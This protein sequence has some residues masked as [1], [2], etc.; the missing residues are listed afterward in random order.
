[1]RRHEYTYLDYLSILVEQLG[2]R[3]NMAA[4]SRDYHHPYKPYDIQLELMNAV[5]DCIADG[6]IGIFESPTGTG[7]SLSLICSSL[8]WLRQT[9]EEML[10]TQMSIEED[11]E[12]PRWA[13]EHARDQKR[14]AVVGQMAELEARLSRIRAKELQQKRRYENGESMAKRIKTETISSTSNIS[15]EAQYELNEYNS[16]DEDIKARHLKHRS[17]DPGLSSASMHL[18]EKLGLV[19]EPS[20]VNEDSIVAD[21]LKIYFCSRTH[22]QL[23]QFVHELVRVDIPAALWAR[24]RG[25]VSG[26]AEEAMANPVIKH[27]PLG[28][29]KNLCINTKV[30]KLGS[31]SAITER[32][33]ELQQ[34]T[35]GKDHKCPYVP[36]NEN[37]TL[38][39]DFRDHT[40]AKIRDIEDLGALGKKIGI[41]PYYASRASIKPS[42]VGVTA[43]FS[44]NKLN[45][46]RLSPCHIRCF[47]R[48]L[49]GKLSVSL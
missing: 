47:Y 4:P 40:L 41:C 21:E 5:Y 36:S 29:R 12:D 35:M 25:A 28:S 6:K 13:V 38:V 32:C 19:P 14:E 44:N 24:E 30:S 33:L 9:Q 48:S 43:H 7:K 37:E 42:E 46:C 39:N 18:M 17:G 22:S 8:Q 2:T 20:S 45:L 23:T 10:E 34:P 31:T 49:L 27:L 26:V 16:E 11:N 1:M 3:S 15:D